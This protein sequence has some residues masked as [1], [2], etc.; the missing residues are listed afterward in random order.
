MPPLAQSPTPSF[1]GL[2]EQH[3]TFTD[4]GAEHGSGVLSPRRFPSLRIHAAR[5]SPAFLP[6]CVNESEH[7]MLQVLRR[8]TAAS[9]SQAVTQLQARLTAV[10]EES[11]QHQRLADER[12][13]LHHADIARIG[14]RLRAEAGR[15]GWCH[16]FE[17]LV[18]ELNEQLT[19]ELTHRGWPYLVDTT[20]TADLTVDARDDLAAREA[21]I[22]TIR[23]AED[24]LRQLA[25]VYAYYTH[26]QDL[27]VTVG[28]RSTSVQADV[29]LR[30]TLDATNERCARTAATPM[31]AEAVATL[32][33]FP[34]VVA[35]A[36]DADTFD[37]S[38]R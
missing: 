10:T 36:P 14:D 17:E 2:T 16:D 31:V 8:R 15:R 28:R 11:A 35:T 6:A 26:A 1:P 13:Q 3:A 7:P 19:V 18:D 32:N 37:I 9:T 5:S 20:L 22:V 29:Q 33:R 12:L 24:Q 25:G 38:L 30:I 27:T 23:Q 34:G 21:A 4:H